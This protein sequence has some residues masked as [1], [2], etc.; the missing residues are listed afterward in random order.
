[1]PW[2]PAAGSA[3]ESV[4]MVR[5]PAYRPAAVVAPGRGLRIG[6]AGWSGSPGS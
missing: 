6:P 1:M 5:S 4:E 3:V 2:R